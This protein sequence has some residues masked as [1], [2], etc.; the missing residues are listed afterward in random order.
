MVKPECF[1]LE[2]LQLPS[3]IWWVC[4]GLTESLGLAYE[5]CGKW[6]DWLMGTFCI[7]QTTLPNI[8]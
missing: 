6:N 8:L 1:P 2:N 5:H 7:V 3:G 4:E